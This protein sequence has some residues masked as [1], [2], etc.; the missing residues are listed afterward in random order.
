MRLYKNIDEVDNPKR[1]SKTISF[2]IE[3]KLQRKQHTFR[4]ERERTK[5][6]K[7]VEQYCRKSPEY[8][9]LI[10]ALK[11]NM[12]YNRCTVIKHLKCG[13]G[14]KYTIEIHHMPFTLF[15]IVSIVLLKREE[16]GEPI[17][18]NMIC[19][20]VMELHY[21]GKVGLIPLSKT[22]HELYHDG[23]I[24][25]PLQFVYQKYDKFA[26]EY[27]AWIDLLPKCKDKIQL[28]IE[29]SQR[30]SNIL[31]DALDV[32]FTYLDVDGFTFPVLPDEWGNILKSLDDPV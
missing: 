1:P 8:R 12:D 20:E 7:T 17:N 24:F 28:I 25:I 6:I 27:E 30:S 22:M 9:E 11:K 14:K 16:L 26:N 31:S 29:M 2:A 5:F 13:N 21:D 18:I 32:E 23:Q 4:S 10:T 3:E 19:N 15:D